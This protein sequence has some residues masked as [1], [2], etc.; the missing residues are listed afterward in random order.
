MAIFSRYSRILES[1]GRSMNV[2]TALSL[3]NRALDEVL[4][5]QES[6][7]DQDTRFAVDWFTQYSM[8]EAAFGDADNLS[9][10]KNTSVQGLVDAGIVHSKAGKVRLLNRNEYPDEWDPTADKRLTIWECTQHLIRLLETKGEMAAAHLTAKLGGR[11]DDARALAYRL[12][13]ICD[14]KGWA[15]EALSYN[16][17]VIAWPEII[18]LSRETGKETEQTSLF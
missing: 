2:R 18:K 10:A 5:E 3:I 8:D 12:Y 1:D 16:S 6:D 14:K 4:S 13:S 9:R 7:L 17:I 11:A 15:Q